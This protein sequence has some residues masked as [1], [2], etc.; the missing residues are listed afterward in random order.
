MS[1]L[2]QL[3][4]SRN[5]TSV[6]FMDFM[7]AVSKNRS[8]L[9]CFFEGEDEKYFSVRLNTIIPNMEWTGINCGG[10]SKVI[11]LRDKIRTHTQ[12]KESTVAFFID[13]DF[14]DDTVNNEEE[15][16]VTPCYSVENIYSRVETFKNILTAE[17][18]MSEFC[19]ISNDFE[20]AISIFNAR[21]NDFCNVILPFNIWIKAHRII[22]KS[23]DDKSKKLNLNNLKIEDLVSINLHEISSVYDCDNIP[24]LFPNSFTITSEQY[25]ESAVYF[26]N[27]GLEKYLRGKQQ[28]EF[29]RVFL[30]HLRE[31]R[32]KKENPTFSKRTPVK[33]Q[34][35]KANILSEL[36]QYAV[37]P[38]CLV[39]YLTNLGAVA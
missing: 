9:V 25:A 37:T 11:S 4:E 34:L 6:Q 5:A 20:I 39:R 30:T 3:R 24:D 35:S 22:E 33:L 1:R 18:G 8:I 21:L 32:S 14:G 12:Y 26:Q 15:F 31:E 29:L 13:N 7:K 2:D 23:T 28:L 16:Y 10:K 19:S 17:F 27:Q 38:S 36:S